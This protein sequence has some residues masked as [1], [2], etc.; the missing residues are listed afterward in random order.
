MQV[1][2]WLPASESNF[3]DSKNEAAPLWRVRFES[4]GIGEADLEEYEIRDAIH[5]LKWSLFAASED[6]EERRDGAGLEGSILPASHRLGSVEVQTTPSGKRHREGEKT[7]AQ[8]EANADRDAVPLLP[9]SSLREDEKVGA[10][11][12]GRGKR[13]R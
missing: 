12:G 13:R 6:S 7:R 9:S 11:E 5:A 8:T 1:V 4:D 2:G 3:F 10:S